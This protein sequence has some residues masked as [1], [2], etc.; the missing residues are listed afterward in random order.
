MDIGRRSFFGMM[1]LAVPALGRVEGSLVGRGATSGLAAR[2]GTGLPQFPPPRKPRPIP[3]PEPEPSA[4]PETRALLKQNQK[5]IKRD[6]QRLFELA[7]ELKKEAEKID[8]AEVLSLELIRKAE[9]IEKLA[10]RIK[11]LARG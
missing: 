6:V 5:D 1:I 8:S 4:K 10:K 7:G 11:A 9:E 3:E 2:Q